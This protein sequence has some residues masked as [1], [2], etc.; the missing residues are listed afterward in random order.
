MELADLIADAMAANPRIAR[1]EAEAAAAWARVPQVRS[2]PDPMAGGTVFGEP[3]HMAEGRMRGTVMLSQTV[4]S[5]KK[6]DARGQEA[7]F[8]ALRLQEEARA[9]RLSIAADVEEAWYRLYLLG[10]LLRINEA[11]RQLI[12]PLVDVAT[13]RVEVGET[14]PGDV[15]LGTLELSRT[16]EERLLLAQ[17]LV[18]RTAALNRLLTRPSDA[19]LPTPDSIEPLPLNQSLQ[20]LRTLAFEAQ[21]Q[22]VAARL[23]TQAAAWGIRVACL[24]GV[25]DVTLSYEHMFMENNPGSDAADPWQVGVAV[26]VPLWHAKYRA[27]EREAWQES[28]AASLNVE[29]VVREYDAMLLDLLAQVRAAERTA[30]LYRDTILP[31]ARQALEVD[32]QA[33]AQ[34]TV[35]FERVIEDAR[36]LL[37]AEA[38]HYRAIVE[39]AVAVA[40]IRQIVGGQLPPSVEQ[41][42]RHEFLPLPDPGSDP[43]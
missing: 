20:E 29:D 24:E 21:P 37:T 8:G 9:A 19:P 25:P 35:T 13:R 23:A 26:S 33:Y 17:Q 12:S 42:N 7:A 36:N 28:L 6:L 27:I 18:S 1:L 5:L 16:E 41:F 39:G 4:P 14:S 3:M 2:L 15:V 30:A 34:G 38:A 10:Q 40:R 11:N 43:D 32:Q 22:I 31:Q